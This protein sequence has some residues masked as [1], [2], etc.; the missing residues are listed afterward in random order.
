MN[1]K[2]MLSLTGDKR[3]RLLRIAF[4]VGIITLL[5]FIMAPGV[6]SAYAD[7]I[8][9]G[10]IT[11]PGV[12]AVDIAQPAVVRIITFINSTLTVHFSSGDAT[13]PQGGSAAYQLILSG[14]GTFISAH[15]DLLTADHVVNPPTSDLDSFLQQVAAQDVANYMNT[16]LHANPQVTATQVAQSLANGQPP[17][18]SHYNPP[19]SRVYL[20]TEYTGPLSAPDFKS[21]PSNLFANVDRIEAQSSFTNQDVAII[22][23]SNMD[24]MAMVQL[25]DSSGVQAQDTLK[26]IGFPG[27][28][29]VSVK[30]TNLLTSSINQIFVSSIKTTDTGAPVIQVGGNVEHGDSGGPALDSGGNVVGIVSFGSNGPGST[31]FLQASNSARMLV[32][33]IGLNTTPGAFQKGW[34]QAFNDYGATAQGH[35]HKAAQEFQQ[36]ATRYPLFKAITPFLNY[37]QKQAQNERVSTGQPTATPTTQPAG[38]SSSFLSNSWPLLIGGLVVILGVVLFGALVF[39]RRSPKPAVVGG[40]GNGR[41]YSSSP[42]QQVQSDHQGRLDKEQGD[43]QGRLDKEGDR[44]GRPYNTPTPL[45][46]SYSQR[47]VMSQS[48]SNNQPQPNDAI[49]A[50]GAPSSTWPSPPAPRPA[51]PASPTPRPS[52]AFPTMPSNNSGNLVPWPCGHMNRPIARFCSVCGEPAPQPPTIRRYEQ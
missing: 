51:P 44:Q 50:F 22:H 25:G 46:S 1:K 36:L 18:T 40:I 41:V 9:G 39:R 42:A 49:T 15:G 26:I 27:N 23:V 5:S 29:D 16:T 38:A 2:A 21:I 30:P 12:R 32:Q 35:W 17:S 34:S 37:A 45:T 20:S 31:S 48:Q 28:G 13:F 11:D 47:P 7:E 3:L 33:S 52:E 6:P 43:R 24:D 14:S 19:Q 10:N 4:V 8:P